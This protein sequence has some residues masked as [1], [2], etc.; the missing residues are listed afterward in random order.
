MPVFSI[1]PAGYVPRMSMCFSDA[2]GISDEVSST[3][4]LPVSLQASA[5]S[6][7]LAGSTASSVVVGPFAP[8]T[9]RAVMLNLSGTWAGQVRI[10]RSTD[11]G[12]TK[13]GLTALGQAYGIFTANICEPVWEEG[14][15]TARLYLDIT[16]TSGT[17]NYRMGQ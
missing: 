8:Q 9:D 14:E 17:L 2:T 6:S 11:L 15:A 4:P 16:L 5:P 3:N 7:P 12:V 13:A 1:A 10:L